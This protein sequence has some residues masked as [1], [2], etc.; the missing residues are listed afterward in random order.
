M[1]K[2]Y[3]IYTQATLD[4][5]NAEFPGTGADWPCQV[6]RTALQERLRRDL[7]VEMAY[8]SWL[9]HKGEEMLCA[10]VQSVSKHKLVEY[11]VIRTW[12]LTPENYPLLEL[13]VDWAEATRKR[14]QDRL[15]KMVQQEV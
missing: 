6:H 15:V 1:E 8:G 10:T 2:A 3:L 14:E 12:E 4:W 5:I 9:V 7:N 11:V 13:V